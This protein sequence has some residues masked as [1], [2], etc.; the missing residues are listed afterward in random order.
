M[1]AGQSAHASAPV[2]AAYE[3]GA[4]GMHAPLL[5]A[6]GEELNVPVG[7]GEQLAVPDTSEKVPASQSAQ[8]LAP[9]A[10]EALPGAQAVQAAAPAGE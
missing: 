8:A 1:P 5:E 4:H 3:P 9:E 7:H 2:L 10:L 6:P